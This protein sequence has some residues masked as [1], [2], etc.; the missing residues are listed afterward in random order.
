MASHRRC[1]VG[2]CAMGTVRPLE[3]SYWRIASPD[4]YKR[5]TVA[6][7]LQKTLPRQ[8]CFFTRVC[9]LGHSSRKRA[10]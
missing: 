4:C 2:E 8:L 5:V 6:A 9:N 7:P 10:A 1:A 3:C